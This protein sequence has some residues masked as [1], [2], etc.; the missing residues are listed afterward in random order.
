MTRDRMLRMRLSAAEWSDLERI[1]SRDGRSVSDVVRRKLFD[2]GDSG[3][4]ITDMVRAMRV[5]NNVEVYVDLL[6][7]AAKSGDMVAIAEALKPFGEPR[8]E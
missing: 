5:L 1:A 2:N 3:D 4:I 8:E 6:V 7:D